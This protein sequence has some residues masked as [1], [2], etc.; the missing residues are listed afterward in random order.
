ML[1]LWTTAFT[2]IN[3]SN[4]IDETKLWTFPQAMKDFDW[5]QNLGRWYYQ[6]RKVPCSWSGSDEFTDYE[7]F[8]IRENK[9]TLLLTLTMRNNEICNSIAHRATFKSNLGILKIKEPLGI[10][11]SGIYFLVAGDYTTFGITYGC[12]KLSVFGDKCDDASITV[13]TRMRFP[14]KKVIAMI[15]DELM[16]LWGITVD[17]LQRVKHIKSCI[18]TIPYSPSYKKW[19][20][21]NS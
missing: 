3:L 14:D 18:Q 16:R 1:L 10:G 8:I 11:F 21:T 6:F 7:A 17:D 9:H 13:R 5:Q 20:Q 12:T 15:N 19:Y 2:L 4:G